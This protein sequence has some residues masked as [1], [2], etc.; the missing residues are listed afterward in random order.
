M[1]WSI[2]LLDG[3]EREVP[4]G[5]DPARLQRRRR[6]AR[7]PGRCPSRTVVTAST[8][9]SSIV[10]PGLYGRSS[11]RIA[12]RVC[13]DLRER[14]V[15]RAEVREGRGAGVVGGEVADGRSWKYVGA[16]KRLRRELRADD[17]AVRARSGCRSA[18]CGN[19]SW[20]ER[21]SSRPDSRS[22]ARAVKTT[23]ATTEA[24]QRSRSIS[25]SALRRSARASSAGQDHQAGGEDDDADEQHDERRRRR[26]G[27][28]RRRRARP[29][30]RRAS[31][32]ARARR[33]AGRSGRG[34]SRPCRA[35]V[36]K[37]V[38]P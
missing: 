14:R 5:R 20:R 25:A 29:S 16:V 37:F 10:R 26:C 38:A 15:G 13:H 12:S 19:A 30:S 33:A 6:P 28:S 36:E 17:L 4:H 9:M 2:R 11:F 8:G 27:T 1:C 18:W 21:R 22:R 23:I 31:R 24:E 3:R 34:A 7:S 32:R 35:S